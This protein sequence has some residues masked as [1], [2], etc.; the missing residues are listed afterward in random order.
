MA[1]LCQ[2]PTISSIEVARVKAGVGSL[3]GSPAV[4]VAVGGT[5]VGVAVGGIAMG[6]TAGG[7]GVDVAAGGPHP[8]NSSV[9]RVAL[10]HC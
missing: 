10:T 8:T 4:G 9:I 5:G 1:E 7:T 2:V 6:V 3:V